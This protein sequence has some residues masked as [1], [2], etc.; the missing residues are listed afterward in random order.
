MQDLRTGNKKLIKDI[1]RALVINEI[2]NKGPISRTAISKNTK[3][4]LSTI[5]KIIDALIKEKLV[6]ETGTETSTG[7]RRPISLQFN[8][9][10]S[11]VIGVKIEVHQIIIAL[12]DLKAEIK[13]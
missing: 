11:N 7:G 12:T 13:Y 4:A 10:Y 9:D 2:R 3:L 1:N 8:Y 6:F 5:T